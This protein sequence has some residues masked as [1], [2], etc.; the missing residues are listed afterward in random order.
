MSTAEVFDASETNWPATLTFKQV[1]EMLEKWGAG[2]AVLMEITKQAQNEVTMWESHVGA[3]RFVV[4][5]V[6]GKVHKHLS[7]VMAS[8]AVDGLADT[9]A[10]FIDKHYD[11]AT[12]RWRRRPCTTEW[13]IELHRNEQDNYVIARNARE[14]MRTATCEVAKD[15]TL[16]RLM[17]DL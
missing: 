1:I 5:G 8:L 3:L 14:I 16:N 6:E 11:S 15:L 17:G 2:E 10:E 9:M 4:R 13:L 12:S 7:V